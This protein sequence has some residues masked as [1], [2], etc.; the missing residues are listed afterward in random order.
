[1]LVVPK[2]P[3][4]L[5]IVL[6]S[7]SLA[8]GL[9]ADSPQRPAP[10]QTVI[11]FIAVSRDGQ[12]ILDLE[13]KEITLEVGGR[14]RDIKVFQLLRAANGPAAPV[15]SAVPP[16]FAT[17]IITETMG[18]DVTVCAWPP[19]MPSGVRE[20]STPTSSRSWWMPRR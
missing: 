17:N 9:V 1:V 6:L 2:M 8:A 13:S 15:P 14:Q 19:S 3:Q 12:P 18:R 7:G 16:P 11:D 5:A 20:R 10:A 4:R